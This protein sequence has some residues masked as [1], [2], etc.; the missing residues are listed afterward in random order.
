MLVSGA[1]ASGVLSYERCMYYVGCGHFS[2]GCS[3]LFHLLFLW[4]GRFFAG[5]SVLGATHITSLS[6]FSRYG[7]DDSE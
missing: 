7:Q 5:T 3:Q 4:Q 1:L 6:F 2:G